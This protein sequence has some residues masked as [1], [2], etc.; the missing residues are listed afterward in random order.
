MGLE[1]E[2]LEEEEL[3]EEDLEP[4][5]L[6]A[7]TKF[8]NVISNHYDKNDCRTVCLLLTRRKLN[9]FFFAFLFCRRLPVIFS[10]G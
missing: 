5:E 1:S 10:T 4:G 7:V 9:N 8:I 2:E 6:D 3:E